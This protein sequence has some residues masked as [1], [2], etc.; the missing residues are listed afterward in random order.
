MIATTY[1]THADADAIMCDLRRIDD[2]MHHLIVP[3]FS[4]IIAPDVPTACLRV[5]NQMV[6]EFDDLDPDAI[7]TP[8]DFNVTFDPANELNSDSVRVFDVTLKLEPV[9]KLIM[10]QF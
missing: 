9:A 6:E 8:A 1:I 4:M 5:V 3:V 2:M 10:R 7:D